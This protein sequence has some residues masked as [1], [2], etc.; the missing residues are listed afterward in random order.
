M[1]VND[2]FVMNEWKIDQKAYNILFIPDGNGEFTDGMGM[3]IDKNDL[4][5]GKRLCAIQC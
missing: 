4:G 3:L 5:F 1:S 2:A